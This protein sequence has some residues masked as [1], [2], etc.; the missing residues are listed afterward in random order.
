M[1]AQLAQDGE[2]GNDAD[3]GGDG[4]DLGLKDLKAIVIGGA[5]T[6]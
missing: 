5:E 3:Q 6:T 2:R 4:M 1:L